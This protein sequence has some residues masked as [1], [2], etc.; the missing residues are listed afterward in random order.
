DPNLRFWFE[1]DGNTRGL[2]G[3]QNNRV[4]PGAAFEPNTTAVS[5]IGGGVTVDHAV[6]L[7]SA[8]VAYDF[9]GCA[10]EKG[11]GPD[12][13]EGTV[14]YAPTYTFIV[15]KFK[16]FMS[17]E[18]YMGSANAQFVEYGMTEWFFDADD[19]NLQT[20][21]G[22]QIRALD[23]RFYLQATIVNPNESQFPNTLQQNYPGFNCGF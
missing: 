22:T 13:P 23:D 10:S 11:C 2:G 21:A 12:C 4:T 3:N 6:R 20:Q 7:F 16:P 8:Y 14:K 5:P 15:G 18:E 9:H 1:L 19:D 17:F